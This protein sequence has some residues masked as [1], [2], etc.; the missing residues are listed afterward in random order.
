MILLGSGTQRAAKSS[1]VEIGGTALSFSSWSAKAE[2]ADLI[3]TNFNSFDT[4]SSGVYSS[5]GVSPAGQS[6]EEGIMGVLKSS[7]SYGG[8]WDAGLNPVDIAAPPGLYPRDDLPSIAL[9][10]AV[11]DDAFWFY[12]WQRIRGCS[13][14]G[15]VADKVTF[16]VDSAMN[17]GSFSFPSG[18]V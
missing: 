18:S 4:T 9:I 15:Q 6:Y 10:V 11:F 2:A 7:C 16:T 17:Q 12:P 3:T 8:D 1:R 13:N 14:S 5:D